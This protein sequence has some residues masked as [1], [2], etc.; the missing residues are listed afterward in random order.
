MPKFEFLELLLRNFS[1]L[2]ANKIEDEKIKAFQNT[3]IFT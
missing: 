2:T 1:V 3:I